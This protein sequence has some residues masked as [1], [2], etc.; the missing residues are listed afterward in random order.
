MRQPGSDDS[1]AIAR[2]TIGRIGVKEGLPDMSRSKS[3]DNVNDSTGRGTEPSRLHER[4]PWR[5]VRRE[6]MFDCPY[7]IA[8]RDTVTHL[9]G[10]ERPYYNIHKKNF[11]IA[12]VPIDHDGSTTLVG[13][14]RYVLDRFTWEVTRGGGR[15]GTP[16]IDAARRE[17]GEE[18]GYAADHWLQLFEASASPGTTDS[19][20]PGFVAWGLHKG[21]PH[22]DPAELITLRRVPFATAVSMALAGEIADLA[23]LSAILAIETRFRRGELPADLM[24]LLGKEDR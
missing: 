2:P 11:G 21:D 22:P 14:Y 23:S 24:R 3:P 15:C 19:M 12:V 20:A 9:G 16:A 8:R 7:Y 17:L 13:Q 10:E 18:T 1:C 4:N 5:L 6:E